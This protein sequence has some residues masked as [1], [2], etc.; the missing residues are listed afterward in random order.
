[1]MRRRLLCLA[2][3]CLLL[4]ASNVRDPLAAEIKRWSDFLESPAASGE[5]WTQVKQAMGPALKRSNDA[6]Q[7]GRVNLA[8][9]RLAAV[10]PT[11]EGA[12]FA[13]EHASADL[14]Q[15]WKR[16]AAAVRGG[17][18]LDHIEP[19][20]LR[21]LAESASSQA[22]VLYRASLDYGRADGTQSGLLYI[23]EARGQKAFVDFARRLSRPTGLRP[24]K[25][26]ALTRT[27]IESLERELLAAYRP[28][29]SLDRHSEF[30]GAGAAIKEARE[31]QA[32]GLRYGALQRYLE[33]A[34]RVGQ[35]TE[36]PMDRAR[37]ESAL[38]EFEARLRA[39]GVDHSIGQLYAEAAE[40]DLEGTA[41]PAVATS[42]VTHVLPLYFAALES[43]QDTRRSRWCAG[44]TRE[45]SPIQQV[46]W[47]RAWR[48]SSTGRSVSGSRITATRSWPRSS[49]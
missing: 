31:L 34:R 47:L 27:E 2:I 1:M 17:S 30:I 9:M 42:V 22:G 3:A 10:V 8:L 6:L 38:H 4:R 28:P 39:G 18:S 36:T 13:K 23:G 7:K 21:A 44:R 29:T 46:C 14:E 12:A 37:I 24:P 33:A 40:S 49:A 25:V 45:T 26:R 41:P 15:E 32:A 35:L 11:F 19:A 5:T 48:R 20:S 43:A 16:N